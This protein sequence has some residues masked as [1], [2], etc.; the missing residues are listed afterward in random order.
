VCHQ[1]HE[2]NGHYICIVRDSAEPTWSAISDDRVT[3]VRKND[4]IRD[5]AYILFYEQQPK[6]SPP[7]RR[8]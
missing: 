6:Q 5:E 2:Y 1:G 7:P 3:E 4:A 8:K